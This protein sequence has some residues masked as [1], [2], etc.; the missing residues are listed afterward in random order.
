MNLALPTPDPARDPWLDL[1]R[2]TAARIA[3][4]RAGGSQRTS[5]L[6]EFRAAHAGAR[7]AVHAPF[8]AA[9]LLDALNSTSLPSLLLASAVNDRFTYLRRPDLGRILASTA[10]QTLIDFTTAPDYV[11]PD[12]VLIVSDGLA[13]QA[14]ENHALATLIP[15]IAELRASGWSLGP[16]CVVPFARVKIQDEIGALLGARYS[17]ML[18]GERPGLSAPDSLG[19]Y[20]TARP[21][22]ECTDADRNCVS[23][24]RPA[25]FAPPLAAR[26][27]AWLLNTSRQTG[28]S[29]VA[30][31]DTQPDEYLETT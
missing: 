11:S 21:S 28:Q 2:F 1:Q 14:A 7:D 29:G 20:F 22:A 3:L 18:L 26:K 31:K 17:L 5:T 24:I 15:L 27:L 25:G 30:L 12:I 13:A 6:L 4:G 10:R 16:I 19:A 23:N 8:A 9:E